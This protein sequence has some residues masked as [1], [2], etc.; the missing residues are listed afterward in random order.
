VDPKTVTIRKKVGSPPPGETA[1]TAD[2]HSKPG[3]YNYHAKKFTMGAQGIELKLTTTIKEGNGALTVTDVWIPR[4][5]L[6]LLT[7]TEKELEA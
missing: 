6:P 4:W 5:A 3:V 7:V 2:R 1:Q